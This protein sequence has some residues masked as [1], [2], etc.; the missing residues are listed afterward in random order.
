MLGTNKQKEWMFSYISTGKRFPMD[1]P[2]RTIRTMVD[3]ILK[4]LSLLFEILYSK[5]G[6][7]SVAPEKLLATLLLQVLYSVRSERL[8]WNS[9][10]TTSC[11]AGLSV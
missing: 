6:R 10:T 2:L 11:F 1:H 5:T 7:P 8:L 3:V 9:W 4:D